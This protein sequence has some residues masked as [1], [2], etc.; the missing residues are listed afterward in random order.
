M[1]I[2][3][4]SEGGGH[5][6]APLAVDAKLSFIPVK[7]GKA[8]RKLELTGSFTFPASPIPWSTTGGAATKRV[9]TVLVDTN[10]DLVPDTLVS[11]STNFWPGWKPGPAMKVGSCTQCEP[12]VCH[13]GGEGQHCTSGVTACYPAQCP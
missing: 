7:P 8:A 2:I 3:R 10:G 9:G 11:G 12:P 1:R 13:D 5:F 4:T 6:L